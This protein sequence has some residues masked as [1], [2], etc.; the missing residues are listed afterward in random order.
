MA[1]VDQREVDRAREGNEQRVG[2]DYYY[3]L[4][5]GLPSSSGRRFSFRCRSAGEIWVDL[6]G[7]MRQRGAPHLCNV[8]FPAAILLERSPPFPLPARCVPEAT[9]KIEV[10]PTNRANSSIQGAGSHAGRGASVTV[11]LRLLAICDP[12]VALDLL[13]ITPTE[14]NDWFVSR[15][16]GLSGRKG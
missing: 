11:I 16:R 1:A 7:E 4:N 15:G 9:K 2:S 5:F 14:G 8:I 13:T 3:P 6:S 10:G 12:V